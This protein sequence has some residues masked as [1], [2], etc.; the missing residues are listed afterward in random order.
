MIL[1]IP[2]LNC[3]ITS[4]SIH[5]TKL[6]EKFLRTAKATL[7]YLCKDGKQTYLPRLTYMGFRYIS[8]QGIEEENV[9][10]RAKA[11]Y[12]ELPVIGDFTCSDKKLNQLN[13]N[14]RWSAKSNFIDIPTDCPQRDERMGWT[15]DIAVF[16]PTACYNFDMSRFLDKWLRDVMAEQKPTGGIPNTIPAQGYGFPATMPV[17]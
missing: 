14:I 12:S 3:V 4:Y 16:S 8:I 10:V 7:T 5:Y 9:T 15:G 11:L 2:I 6:Y 17:P 1:F 13:S